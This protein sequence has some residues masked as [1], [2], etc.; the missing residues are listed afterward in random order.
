M[1][2]LLGE[3]AAF[4][5]RIARADLLR[6]VNALTMTLLL[7]GPCFGQFFGQPFYMQEAE[8]P[9]RRLCQERLTLP[10]HKGPVTSLAVSPDGKTLATASANVNQP[11]EIKLW[12]CGTLQEKRTLRGQAAPILGIAFSP[13]NQSLASAGADGLVTVWNAATE[14]QTALKGHTGRVF[15]VAF[16][17]NSQGL[18]SAGEDKT[19]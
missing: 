17:P 8:Q 12:D 1:T 19:V 10:V 7:G 2:Q 9:R 4:R 14:A 11:G 5:C 18:A 15:C 3:P 6:A 13:D 16:S